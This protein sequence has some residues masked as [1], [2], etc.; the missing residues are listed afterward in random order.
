MNY[1]GIVS[2][3]IFG[4]LVFVTFYL[5]YRK[6]KRNKKDSFGNTFDFTKMP[7]KSIKDKK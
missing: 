7:N 5:N 2:L 1:L 4:V 6:G 3:L